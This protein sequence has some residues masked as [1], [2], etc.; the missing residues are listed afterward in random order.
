MDP[1]CLVVLILVEDPLVVVDS[2]CGY[3]AHQEEAETGE[4]GPSVGSVGCEAVLVGQRG[5][6]C[7]GLHCAVVAWCVST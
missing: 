6:V 5:K 7:R 1:S 2:L 4:E 3:A